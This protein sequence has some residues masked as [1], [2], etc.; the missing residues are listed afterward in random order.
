MAYSTSGS[1]HFRFKLC[2]LEMIAVTDG[3]MQKKNC[4]LLI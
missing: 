1:G 3:H 4:P 2:D